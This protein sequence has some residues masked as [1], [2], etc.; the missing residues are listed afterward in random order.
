MLKLA[1]VANNLK[2]NVITA[3][4]SPW[5]RWYSL[6]IHQV[7]T[8]A[9]FALEWGSTNWVDRLQSYILYFNCLVFAA[10]CVSKENVC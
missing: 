8:T 1:Q 6:Y 3:T 4:H 9:D 2:M 5:Y 7:T 10:R